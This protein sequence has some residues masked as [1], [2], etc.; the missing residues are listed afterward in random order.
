MSYSPVAP[1]MSGNWGSGE[2]GNGIWVTNPL[3]ACVCH[4]WEPLTYP[5]MPLSARMAS[6]GIQT[7][8]HLSPVT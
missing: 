6:S 5:I 2:P 8:Q 3:A 1:S 4:R 7:V